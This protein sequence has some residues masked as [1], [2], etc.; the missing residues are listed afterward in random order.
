MVIHH[1][2]TCHA[3][4]TLATWARTRPTPPIFAHVFN[5]HSIFS[6]ALI[7]VSFFLR[8]VGSAGMILVRP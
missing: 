3:Q 7:A 1:A 6:V 8:S 2:S 5:G 4:A